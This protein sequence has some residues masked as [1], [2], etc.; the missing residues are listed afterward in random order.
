VSDHVAC[1]GGT[2]C[3]VQWYPDGSHWRSS[4]ARA[5]TSRRGCASPTPDR[6]GA[7]GVRGDEQTQIGD[8]S[9]T[10]NLWRVLP[11]TT[12]DLVV[13]ARRLGA[14]L[15]VR[16]H[17]RPLKNR[18]TTGD[19]QRERDRARRRAGAPIYFTANGKEAGR[20]P[21]FQHLYRV[22]F[23]G[24]G[25]TLLTPEVANHRWRCR[26]T[27]LLH[28][29][30]YS[31]PDTPPVTVLRDA[32]GRVLRDARARRHLAAARAAAGSRRRRSRMKARDGRPTSTA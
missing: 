2:I 30:T 15:P 10:E 32:A 11:A 5:I 24:S 31:T 28:F 16:P 25:L 21:Y 14:P 18:I 1:G 23:D 29:D 7:H 3:D 12:S 19:G 26:P 17:D 4:P 27:A 22:G 6:R 20:D 8:A 13:A 9:L